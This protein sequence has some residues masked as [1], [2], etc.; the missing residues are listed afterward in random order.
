MQYYI[1]SA[2]SVKIFLFAEDNDHDQNVV[3]GPWPKREFQIVLSDLFANLA[4]FHP[5]LVDA[6]PPSG[7]SSFGQRLKF[8]T[9]T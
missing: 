3:K 6:H 5:I 9:E 1:E 8:Q 2:L 7:K 4:M